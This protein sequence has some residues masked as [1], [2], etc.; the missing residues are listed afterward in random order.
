VPALEPVDRDQE[1]ACLRWREL[2]ASTA[3]QLTGAQ[4]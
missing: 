1:V 2:T 4:A 3:P